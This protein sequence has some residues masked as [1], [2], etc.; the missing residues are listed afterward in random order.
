MWEN[1]FKKRRYNT[2]LKGH[3]KSLHVSE[4]EEFIKLETEKK[5][6]ARLQLLFKRQKNKSFSRP[7]DEELK[8]GFSNLKSMETDNL[9]SQMIALQDVT[10]NFVEGIGFRRLLQ[11]I[12]A[13]YQLRRRHYF[14][15]F[16]C[17]DFYPKL[18]SKL[19]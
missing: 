8:M 15:S 5:G 6:N 4:Y 3:L 11:F 10:F 2:S 16:I 18:A 7:F 14:A 9:I 1:V 19:I 13:N 17:D 12:V